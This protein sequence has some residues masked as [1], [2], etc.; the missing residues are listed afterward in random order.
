MKLTDLMSP[1]L[2]RMISPADRRS[3]GLRTAAETFRRGVEKAEKKLQNDIAGLLRRR[4]IWFIWH[5]LHKKSTA[6]AGTPDFVFAT[7]FGVLTVASGWECKLPGENL[8]PDQATARRDMTRGF[9]A[10]RY[11]IIH[12]YDEA[13]DELRELGLD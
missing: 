3:L 2:M 13:L 8:S 12:T 11:R 4:G 1:R 6:T 7:R 9:N 10:W 5:G